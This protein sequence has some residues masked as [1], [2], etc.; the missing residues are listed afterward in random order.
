MRHHIVNGEQ[1]NYTPE[2]ESE[3]DAV[4]AAYTPPM[5]LT[6]AEV[7][8]QTMQNN[9]LLRALV[10]ALNDGSLIPGANATGVQLKAVIKA[11]M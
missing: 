5:P 9:K 2:E 7:Y 6:S 4:D 1:V 10:L 3:Q 8:D 11:K